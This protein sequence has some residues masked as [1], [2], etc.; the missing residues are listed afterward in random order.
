MADFQKAV[1]KTL[2]YE[3]GLVDNPADPGGLTNHGISIAAHPEFTAAQIRDMSVGQA[4]LIY[5]DKYWEPIYDEIVDQILAEQLFDFGVTSG[6]R[7]AIQ[8]LQGVIFHR[9]GPA[10]DGFFGNTT[11]AQANAGGRQL[12]VNFVAERLR[13]YAALNRPE[14]LHSWFS[15]TIDALLD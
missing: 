9:G 7:T 2:R 5:C 14:F 6:V 4:S 12:R 1:L 13:F 8:T 15:R 3:G 11:L 10:I